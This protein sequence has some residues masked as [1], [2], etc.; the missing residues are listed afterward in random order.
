MSLVAHILYFMVEFN[1]MKSHRDSI[2]RWWRRTQMKNLDESFF[3]VVEQNFF[4][5]WESFK[6][7]EENFA[8]LEW[9][10][11]L[12]QRR[13]HSQIPHRSQLHH[14]E[15]TESI[16]FMNGEEMKS[17]K[18][19]FKKFAIHFLI[20]QQVVYILKMFHS[21]LLVLLVSQSTQKVFIKFEFPCSPFLVDVCFIQHTTPEIDC[22]LIKITQYSWEFFLLKFLDKIRLA[23][24][25]KWSINFD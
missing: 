21:P 13:H 7:C 10:L 3:A 6:L 8:V 1:T 19:L 22:L 20:S 17:M 24:E 11:T 23:V 5:A 15:T 25:L 4:A 14:E 9:N 12:E 18:Y 16:I 2:F